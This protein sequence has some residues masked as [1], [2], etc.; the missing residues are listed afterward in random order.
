[1]QTYNEGVSNVKCYI[2]ILQTNTSQ[3]QKP[4]LNSFLSYEMAFAL[5]FAYRTY[6]LEV[7]KL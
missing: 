5:L 6:K 1:M 7:A 2:K 4:F 3:Q